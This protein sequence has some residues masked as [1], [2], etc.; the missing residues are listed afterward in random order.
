VIRQPRSGAGLPVAV[1]AENAA[2]HLD[3]LREEVRRF[4]EF[5]SQQ[6]EQVRREREEVAR[7]ATGAASAFVAREHELNRERA[8]VAARAAALERWQ[9]DLAA[10]TAELERRLAE[11]DRL[12][13]SVRRR[14]CEL[15]ELEEALRAEPGSPPLA[16]AGPTALR[17]DA[18]PCS[19]GAEGVARA[20]A[21]DPET[22]APPARPA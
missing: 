21:G 13:A 16:D 14:L 6:F 10:R 17:L 4:N 11:V 1:T 19:S 5:V 2:A 7:S 12:E 20:L 3:W 22:P 18:A 9:R 8:D 15:D